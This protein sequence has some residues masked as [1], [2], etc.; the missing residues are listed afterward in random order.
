[1]RITLL[2]ASTVFLAAAPVPGA[3]PPTPPTWLPPQ[4]L[5]LLP[6]CAALAFSPD[7]RTLAT[8]PH[9]SKGLHLWELATRQVRATLPGRGGWD[10][11]G[12]TSAFSPDGRWLVA[13][14]S[15][16]GYR[17]WDLSR[18][19]VMSA[20]S[21]ELLRRATAPGPGG[22]VFAAPIHYMQSTE[23]LLVDQATGRRLAELLK[24][25]GEGPALAISRDGK[26]LATGGDDIT[27]RLWDV[28]AGRVRATLAA[29]VHAAAFSPCGRLLATAEY[30]SSGMRVALRDASTGKVVDVWRDHYEWRWM[31]FS[32]DGRLLICARN[33]ATALDG[34]G[35]GEVR[36]WDVARRR[37]MEDLRIATRDV[38]GV[39]ISPNGTLLAVFD[40]AATPNTHLYRL[41]ARAGQ[42]SPST[43]P[44]PARG[45]EPGATHPKDLLGRWRDLAGGDAEKAYRAVWDLASR[46]KEAVALLSAHLTPVPRPDLSGVRPLIA[47]LGSDSYEVRVRATRELEKLGERAEP[48]L[49]EALEGRPDLE[50]RRRAETLL[51]ALNGPLPAGDRLRGVRAVEALELM[52]TPLARKL[53][54]DLAS[55]EPTARLTREASA[56]LRRLD[57]ASRG[58]KTSG[59]R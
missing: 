29:H 54:E 21:S 53:L 51:A 55:G 44:R 18:L 40:R 49:L 9:A 50:L 27:V 12:A 14:D 22:K 25:G 47:R 57:I 34:R 17:L 59:K 4:P 42:A 5:G 23:A 6:G 7:C 36:F 46:P 2:A 1:M 11:M 10:G 13:P 16:A 38:G 31:A 58:L 3:A 30:T 15:G 8:A 35:Q 20:F 52:A 24:F 39:V 43:A 56:S 41:P 48:A 33:T 26:G 19:R 32:P 37:E 28:L 45:V